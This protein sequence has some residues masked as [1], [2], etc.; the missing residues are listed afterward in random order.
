MGT[1]KNRLGEAVLRSTH[2]LC[3]GAKIRKIGIPPHTPVFFYIK[4]GLR[5]YTFHGHVF[6]M[7]GCAVRHRLQLYQISYSL[8]SKVYACNIDHNDSMSLLR[9]ECL[10]KK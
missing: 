6:L 8:L 5:G 3:F 9:F 10:L 4:V 2:N 1:R 7:K